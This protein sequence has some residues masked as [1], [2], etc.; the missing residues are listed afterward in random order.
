MGILCCRISEGDRVFNDGSR[1]VEEW[2]SCY[3][4]WLTQYR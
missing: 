3:F 1:R 2:V 4:L